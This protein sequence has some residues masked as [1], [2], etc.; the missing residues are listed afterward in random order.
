MNRGFT[1]MELMMVTAIVGAVTGIS[2]GVIVT[3][4]GSE[5]HTRAYIDDVNGLRRAVRAVEADLRAGR[6]DTCQ[7]DDGVLRRGDEVLA[8]RVELFEVVRD[9]DLWVARIGLAK[10]NETGVR[11][12]VVTVRVRPR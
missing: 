5:R 9:G 2:S 12:P 10:R 3:L 6:S 8:R 1:L 4:H 7:L 11:Q